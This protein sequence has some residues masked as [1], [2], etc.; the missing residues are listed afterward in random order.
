MASLALAAVIGLLVYALRVNGPVGPW[1]LANGT[2][3][4]LT[5]AAPV[6]VSALSK[7]PVRLGRQFDPPAWPVSAGTRFTAWTALAGLLLAPSWA[8][9]ATT[10]ASFGPDQLRVGIFLLPICT[11]AALFLARHRRQ[12]NVGAYLWWVFA[13]VPAGLLDLPRGLPIA[14]ALTAVASV[15]G[16]RAIRHRRGHP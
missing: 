1:G 4:G 5:F 3:L 7:L 12:V 6:V 10:G 2:I 16:K 13:C 15:L 11:G 8:A 14:L 9:A